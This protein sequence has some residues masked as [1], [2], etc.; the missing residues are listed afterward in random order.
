MPVAFPMA[1]PTN[2]ARL[3]NTH[4]PTWTAAS[5]A[6]QHWN[7]LRHP[8]LANGIPVIVGLGP[9]KQM[10]RIATRRI[11]AMMTDV[12]SVRDWTNGQQPSPSVGLLNPT[13]ILG[14]EKLSIAE[15]IPASGPFPAPVSYVNFFPE[16]MSDSFRKP[17]H[18]YRLCDRLVGARQTSC[19]AGPYE[20]N[21]VRRDTK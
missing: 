8:T 9:K 16:S 17:S 15:R 20:Y 5:W 6:N 7:T 19:L 13:P 11:V 14:N 21:P 18:R 12:Q 3:D 2:P 4:P 10:V 1:P